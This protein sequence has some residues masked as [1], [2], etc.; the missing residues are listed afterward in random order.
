M[1]IKEYICIK[2][3]WILYYGI[4]HLCSCERDKIAITSATKMLK[5]KYGEEFFGKELQI[6]SSRSVMHCVYR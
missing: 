2:L 4:F 3:L 6:E 1:C 5:L